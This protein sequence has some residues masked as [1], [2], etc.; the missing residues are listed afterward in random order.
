[1]ETQVS[2]EAVAKKEPTETQDDLDQ[3]DLKD[4]KVFQDHQEP[5]DVKENPE[6]VD[7]WEHQDLQVEK[8]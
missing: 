1:M 4:L 8:D 5:V 2:R 7:Q 6:T 3:L